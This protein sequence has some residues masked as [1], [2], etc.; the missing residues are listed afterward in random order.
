MKDILSA[1]GRAELDAFASGNVLLGFDYDGTLAP[2]A[3]EP[4]RARM[5]ESTHLLLTEVSRRYPCVIVSG[6]E[7]KDVARFV[8]QVPLLRIVGNH[9]LEP[10]ANQEGRSRPAVASWRR[11]LEQR[12]PQIGGAWI[13]DKTWSLAVHYRGAR[14][15]AQARA[16]IVAAAKELPDARVLHGKLVVNLVPEGGANKGV[17]LREVRKQLGCDSALYV[18]D[19]VTDEDVFALEPPGVLLAIRV[20]Q[21]RQTKA[22][23]CLRHQE[24]IDRLLG[25]LL[26][27]RPM[28]S[29]SRP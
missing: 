15:P 4:R 25:A 13:E 10:D 7:R 17:A 24:D 27:L 23:W 11:Q 1:A 3:P 8:R 14:R 28:R 20:G 19:D 9:G 5:A 29:R 6:R 22:R 21:S 18:G 12:I 16:A 26:E 2:I